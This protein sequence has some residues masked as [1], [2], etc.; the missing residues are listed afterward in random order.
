M[1][2][3]V[4]DLQNG[5]DKSTEVAL[6]QEYGCRHTE[7]CADPERQQRCVHRAPDF[8]ENP[9]LILVGIPRTCGQEP[10]T[11]LPDC[12]RGS[13]GNPQDNEDDDED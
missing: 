5:E 7:S 8:G 4:K 9:E 12:R 6:T 13:E 2:L 10:Q 3:H 1:E 11:I